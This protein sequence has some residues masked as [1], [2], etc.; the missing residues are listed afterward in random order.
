[1]F[2][3]KQK[4]NSIV[5]K[6]SPRKRDTSSQKEDQIVS[7]FLISFSSFFLKNFYTSKYVRNVVEMEVLC[8]TKKML[9]EGIFFAL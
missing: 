7:A 8:R 3:G 2:R 6:R 1:M 9:A 5:R 4:S